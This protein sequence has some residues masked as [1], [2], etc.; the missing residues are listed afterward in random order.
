MATDPIHG[1][2][3]HCVNGHRLAYP[4]VKISWVGG[5]ASSG[6]H[7]VYICLTCNEWSVKPEDEPRAEPQ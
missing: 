7:D 2:P 4:N 1:G 5:A 6:G 3:T